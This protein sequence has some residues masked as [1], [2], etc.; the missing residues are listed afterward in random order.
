MLCNNQSSLKYIYYYYYYPRVEILFSWQNFLYFD[1]SFS[2]SCLILLNIFLLVHL[3]NVAPN[4]Y[5]I[6]FHFLII[7]TKTYLFV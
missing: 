1:L 6:T 3:R 5:Q 4:F 2:F 7:F